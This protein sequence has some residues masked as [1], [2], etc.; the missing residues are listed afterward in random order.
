[1]LLYEKKCEKTCK[2]IYIYIDARGIFALK[3]RGHIGESYQK[4]HF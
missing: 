1:M 3:I 2:Y 4:L